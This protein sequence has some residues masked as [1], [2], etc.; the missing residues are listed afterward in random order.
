MKRDLIWLK[1]DNAAKIYPA[2]KSKKWINYFRLSATLRHPIAPDILQKALNMTVK[3]FP[4]ISVKLRRGV[5][6]YYLEE[7]PE[8]P[9]IKPDGP[10]PLV[11]E[12]VRQLSK[13]AF[14]VLY[15]KNRIAVE[16]FHALTDGTGGLIFLKTLVAQYIRLRYGVNIPCT[17][18]ILDINDPPKPEELEDSFL[19]NGGYVCREREVQKVYQ[20]KGTK[21]DDGIIHN[22]VAT[23]DSDELRQ[24]AKKYNATVTNFLCSLLI[25]SLIEIQNEECPK[26]KKQLPVHVLI[27]VN[28][29]PLFGSCTMRNFAQYIIPGIDP[30]LGDYDLEEITR[31]VYYQMGEEITKKKMS[32]RIQTNIAAEKSIINRIPPLFFKNLIMKLIYTAVGERTSCLNISNLGVVKIPDAMASYVNRFD[33]IIGPPATNHHNCSVIS[34]NG[35]VNINFVRTIEESK[36]E[37]VFCSKLRKLGLHVLVQSNLPSLSSGQNNNTK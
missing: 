19:K 20:L 4:S 24:I 31:S 3:R 15:Y 21:T 30:R 8:G 29:R 13:C 27:P 35:K 7:L 12:G 10:Q 32:A 26:K 22:I 1:L 36:L 16:Y 28:L 37:M 23:V 2:A 6:W 11:S 17:D 25:L 5:F 34:Y 33:F 18:G 9:A 14:R